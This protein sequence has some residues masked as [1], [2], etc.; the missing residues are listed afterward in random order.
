MIK[1]YICLLAALF[2][3]AVAVPALCEDAIP[4]IAM[5]EPIQEFTVKTIDG[6]TFSLT[7]ALKE[8]KA[9]FINYFRIGCSV[10]VDEM[11]LFN[12]LM[13]KY[14]DQVAFIGLDPC[15]GL[16]TVEELKMLRDEAPIAMKVALVED[17]KVQ[18]LVP[19][20]GYPCN[21]V[22]DQKGRLVL[23]QD[24]GFNDEEL[25]SK[26]FDAILAD[27]YDGTYQV[28]NQYDAVFADL[29]AREKEE[30]GYIVAVFDQNENP[31]P[32]A[33]INFCSESQ[34]VCRLETTN[35]NGMVY[36]D[37]PKDVYHI[38]IV[39]LPDGYSMEEGLEKYTEAEFGDYVVMVHKD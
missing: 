9:V 8:K 23:Y 28:C 29:L 20:E 10:C 38:E 6:E 7:E 3:L 27:G 24:Y 35:E 13:E 19:Y 15:A 4:T 33:Y 32:D 2:I 30:Q 39:H 17:P 22:V 14:G 37:V 16:D 34:G 1:K 31:V 36:F 18:Q 11:P 5:G 21:L 25:L 12:Q 26:T